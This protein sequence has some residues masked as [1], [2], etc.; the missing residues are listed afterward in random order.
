M[1]GLPPYEPNRLPEG[2]Y[3]F[4]ISEE[5]QK[6]SRRRD[7]GKV[8]TTVKMSFRVEVRSGFRRHRESIGVW[9]DRYR[10]LL[11]AIGA[12]EDENGDPHLSQTT[13]VVGRNFDADIIHEPDKNDP[14]KFWARIANIEVPPREAKNTEEEEDVPMPS[15]NNGEP[16]EPDEELPF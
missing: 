4:I 7:D 16:G 8:T 9:E 6:D 15:G 14:T 12:T 11:F 2:H 1:N 13:D 3:H 5:P 10:D